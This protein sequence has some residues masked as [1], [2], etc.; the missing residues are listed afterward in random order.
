MWRNYVVEEK[1]VIETTLFDV[2]SFQEI[3]T[4][5]FLGLLILS[6]YFITQNSLDG[7]FVKFLL[8]IFACLALL[9]EVRCNFR[10]KFRSKFGNKF[11]SKNDKGVQ[12]GK[13]KSLFIQKNSIN[14][15]NLLINRSK[16]WW[17]CAFFFSNLH[18]VDVII[19]QTVLILHV[20]R[21]TN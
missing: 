6:V 16:Q 9:P 12:E 17:V 10:S 11:R 21:D 2:F 3:D 4:F 15:S 13:I 7:D 5:C 19:E 8:V 14:K 20:M 18:V 1:N